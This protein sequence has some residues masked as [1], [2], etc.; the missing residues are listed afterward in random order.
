MRGIFGSIKAEKTNTVQRIV[1]HE[2]TK[3]AILEAVKSPRRV[4]MDLVH[5]QQARRILDRLVGYTLSPLLWKKIRYGLSAGRVQSVA[6]KLI[7]DRE[8][9]IRAFT[10]EEYWTITA[11]FEKGGKTFVS[12]FQKLDG[13]KFV[14][15]NKEES[16]AIVTA[17]KGQPF[18]VANIDEKEV[19]RRPSPPFTTSTLQQEA[20]RKLG[21]R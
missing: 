9:E 21:F 16:D 4:N 1:F 13:K 17:L 18:S 12:E 7:V 15:K 14:P 20:A 6:V 10:P 3:S 19:K 2:I 11:P 5:A 8:R